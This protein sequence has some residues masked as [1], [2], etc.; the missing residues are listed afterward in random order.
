M[1]V[2]PVS[3]PNAVV[4]PAVKVPPPD[5]VRE[6]VP[7]FPHSAI[8]EVDRVEPDPEIVVLLLKTRLPPERVPPLMVVSPV[9]S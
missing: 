8:E 4:V 9:P 2:S 5:I 6:P 3:R 1:P 7:F